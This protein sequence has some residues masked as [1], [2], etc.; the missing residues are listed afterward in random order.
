MQAL[1]SLPSKRLS[2]AVLL[3]RTTAAISVV[4]PAGGSSPPTLRIKAQPQ[5]QDEWCWAAVSST[6]SRFFDPASS[7]T[8]CNVVSAELANPSC[9]QNG[10][11]A[12]CNV[13]W[14]LDHALT[15]TGNLRGML[16]G[17]LPSSTV[18]G[19]IQAGFPLCIRVQWSTG[20]GHF[21]LISGALQGS[22]GQDYVVLSDPI[23]GESSYA[24]SDLT[25][26]NYTHDGGTWTHTYRTQP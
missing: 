11:T 21:L 26:G 1:P 9:C 5:E 18:A 20:G 25:S 22:D 19:E 15:R 12:G 13:Q 16:N 14:Y 4:P 3:G 7:W 10:A 6:V 2:F 24:I 8:Q 23:Y 17:S